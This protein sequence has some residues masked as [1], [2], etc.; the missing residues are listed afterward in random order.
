MNKT[1][2]LCAALFATAAAPAP[3]PAPAK[4]W[5][6]ARADARI[7][8]DELLKGIT[9]DKSYDVE[10]FKTAMEKVWAM[11]ENI[12]R[13]QRKLHKAR[14]AAAPKEKKLLGKLLD[15]RLLYVY[16]NILPRIIDESTVTA[17]GRAFLKSKLVLAISEEDFRAKDA[18]LR[19][20]SKLS[21]ELWDAFPPRETP[22]DQKP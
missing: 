16:G 11:A 2:L 19:A 7:W 21:D 20:R 17:P 10:S 18:A 8:T 15:L 14:L 6:T 1:L 22:A 9:R 13:N 3:D 4:P 5:E 12:D